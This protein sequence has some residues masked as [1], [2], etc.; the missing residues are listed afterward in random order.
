M[1][2]F[3]K[4]VEDSIIVKLKYMVTISRIRKMFNSS[5]IVPVALDISKGDTT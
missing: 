3:L 4:S 5:P 1:T 2:H